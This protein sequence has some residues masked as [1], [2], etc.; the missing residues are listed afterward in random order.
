MHDDT[1]NYQIIF[2]D[3]VMPN[4]SGPEATSAIRN[5]GFLN[6]IIGVTGNAFEEAKQ[7]FLDSGA[8]SVLVKPVNISTLT[9]LL[10]SK[11]YLILLPNVFLL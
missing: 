11:Q 9:N 7:S 10:K 5:L 1:E 4:M 8:T 2:M 3:Y 6:P